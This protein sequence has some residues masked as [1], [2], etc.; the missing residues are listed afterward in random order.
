MCVC[1]SGSGKILKEI[2]TMHLNL[3]LYDIDQTLTSVT[4]LRI[5]LGRTFIR[6]MTQTSM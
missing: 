1:H 3:F 2:Y 5:I 4:N 6:E